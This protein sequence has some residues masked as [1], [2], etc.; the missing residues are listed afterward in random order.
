MS[1]ICRCDQLPYNTGLPNS[2]SK[3][4][5]QAVVLVLVMLKTD[6]GAYNSIASGAVL[7]QAYLDAKTQHADESVRWYPLGFNRIQNVVTE[8]AESA[9]VSYDTGNSA[10]TTQGVRKFSGIFSGSGADVQAILDSFKCKSIG[11]YAVGKCGNIIGTVASDG[12]LRPTPIF[13]GSLETIMEQGGSSDRAGGIMLSFEVEQLVK[14]SQ[15]GYVADS[16]ITGDLLNLS[17]LIEAIPVASNIS[18]TGFKL[19]IDT[20][21]GAF[22]DKVPVEGLVLVDFTVYNVTDALSITVTSVTE[23]TAGVYT[24]V[25]PSQTVADVV[26][27]TGAVGALAKN[28][29][30]EE[31]LLTIV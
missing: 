13:T 9:A 26:R 29:F 16:A 31:T 19:A 7:N 28:F 30:V 10:K 24:F 1:L 20:L 25:I 18:Q 21:S 12:S 4:I 22:D 2:A 6:A 27:V 17:G 14:D 8:R 15:L 3:V 11:F 5:N 23:A